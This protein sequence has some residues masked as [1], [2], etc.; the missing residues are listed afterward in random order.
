MICILTPRSCEVLPAVGRLWPSGDDDD[1]ADGE[2]DPIGKSGKQLNAV[3]T[4]LA[5][6]RSTLHFPVASRMMITML[7]VMRK[8]RL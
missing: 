4:T 8:E 1:V 6:S 5:M 3:N 7:V 2:D